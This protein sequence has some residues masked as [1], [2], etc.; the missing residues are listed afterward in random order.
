M[1]HTEAIKLI[2][3]RSGLTQKDIAERLSVSRTAITMRVNR[4]AAYFN[5]VLEVLDAAG[6]EMVAMPKNGP[7]LQKDAYALRKEDYQ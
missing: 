6:Y 4:K 5:N 7:P 2:M 3:N 1:N